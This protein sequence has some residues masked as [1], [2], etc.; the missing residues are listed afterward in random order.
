M[1]KENKKI[2]INKNLKKEEQQM[3]KDY[4]NKSNID[5]NIN[6]IM[7]W[8]KMIEIWIKYLLYQKDW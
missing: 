3:I 2:S 1:E 5:K 7:K 8:K 4:I 6:N